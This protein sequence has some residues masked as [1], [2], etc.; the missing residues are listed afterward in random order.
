MQ[1]SSKFSLNAVFEGY[2]AFMKAALELEEGYSLGGWHHVCLVGSYDPET[3]VGKV[4]INHDGMESK[5]GKITL[6]KKC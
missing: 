5:E 4:R 6:L 1:H 3:K 2:G